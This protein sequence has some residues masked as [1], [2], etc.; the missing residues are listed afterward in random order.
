L[1]ASGIGFAELMVL[2]FFSFFTCGR[3]AATDDARNE[4]MIPKIESQTET[5]REK[6]VFSEK[7]LK[8]AVEKKSTTPSAVANARSERK[9]KITRNIG[10]KK[11]V[12]LKTEV[13][14]N[15]M[16]PSEA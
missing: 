10:D 14:K 16:I 15:R 1:L 7:P 5:P 6:R 9:L 2:S 12:G 8:K 3:N 11:A 4:T 13:K